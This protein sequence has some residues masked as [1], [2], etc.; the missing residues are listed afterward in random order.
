MVMCLPSP[1]CR[2][3]VGERIGSSRVDQWGDS[4]KREALAGNGWKVRHDRL[5][6]EIVR[7][8]G[9]SGVVATCEVTG[10]FQHLIPQEAMSRVEVQNARQVMIP[11]FRLQLPAVG[12][13]GLA[14]A[15]VDPG[16][17]ETRLAE[18]K[19]TCGQNLYK[20]G[21]RQ[22]Q[23]A[24]AVDAR[25][26]ALMGEY[27]SK[28]DVMDRLLG[29]EEGE[30]RVRRRLDQFGEL[31]GLV[32]GLFNEASQDFHQ[33]LDVMAESRVQK[34]AMSSGLSQGERAAEKGRAQGE[35]RVQISTCSLRAGM[36]CLLDRVHQI[37]ET[38]SL[39]SKR[40][41]AAW[42]AEEEMR[43][44]REAQFLAR[45]RGRHLLQRKGQIMS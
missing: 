22:R 28:A 33:L 19:F 34:V 4:L 23:F 45:V 5:K 35:L 18:L 26:G 12:N 31:I 8:L 16:Q 1:A 36:A 27:R 39:C 6:L 30:G 3:R 24:R 29:A 11:D 17:V 21:V 43:R 40:R 13:V 9:W 25:A 44:L 2:D 10:L 7:L 20:P 41:E 15:G 37:G 32:S 38:A 42:Q 14:T